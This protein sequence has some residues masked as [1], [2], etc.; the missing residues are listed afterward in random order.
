MDRRSASSSFV[1]ALGLLLAQGCAHPS[2]AKSAFDGDRTRV[3][4]YLAGQGNVDDRFDAGGCRRCTLLHHAAYG[5]RIE[6]ARLLVEKGADVNATEANG[7]TP[8]HVACGE[9]HVEM[10]KFLLSNGSVPSLKVRDAWGN[11]PLILTVATRK[12]KAGW[13]L[14]KHGAVA[15]NDPASNPAAQ[16]VE[17]LVAAG[18]DVQAVTSKGNTAL[19]IAAY[20]GY[21][22]LVSLLLEKGA[23][24]KATNSDGLT[25]EALAQAYHQEDVVKL[26]RAS[27]R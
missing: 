18:A 8:L 22:D 3:S 25:A 15:V 27:A 16:L 9:Q 24:R 21:G 1:V 2:I 20:K 7:Y 4:E 11:T 14:I 17:V 6:V 10:A 5:G 26:L 19:H 23:D 12:E 13:I